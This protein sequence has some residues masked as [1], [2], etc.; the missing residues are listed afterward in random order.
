MGKHLCFCLPAVVENVQDVTG[1]GLCRALAGAR[2]ASEPISVIGCYLTQSIMDTAGAATC[3]GCVKACHTGED[4]QGKKKRGEHPED[5]DSLIWFA[6]LCWQLGKRFH[7]ARRA[8]P[9]AAAI[10]TGDFTSRRETF[11][12]LFTASGCRKYSI[13]TS[14]LVVV[15]GSI[16]RLVMS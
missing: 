16:A 1:Y 13:T 8:S 7:L 5:L 4:E 2:V 15:I 10:L 14:L 9:A 3:N 11:S 12:C 6:A